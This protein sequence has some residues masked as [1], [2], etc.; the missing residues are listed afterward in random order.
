MGHTFRTEFG[1]I[2]RPSITKSELSVTLIDQP[3]T[4]FYHEHAKDDILFIDATGSMVRQ[5][6]NFKKIL[7]YA[8]II[9]HP[10]DCGPPMPVAEY[11]T[12]NQDPFSIR[13]FLNMIQE[14]ECHKYGTRGK[15]NPK[16][17]LLDFSMALIQACLDEFCAEEFNEYLDRTHCIVTGCASNHALAKSILHICAFHVMKMCRRN[18]K[19]L[20][21]K[22]QDEKSQ[23]HFAS[24]LMGRLINCKSLDEAGRI[25]DKAFVVLRTKKAT[26]DMQD[27]LHWLEESINTFSDIVDDPA[28]LVEGTDDSMNSTLS[29]DHE[30]AEVEDYENYSESIGGARSQMHAFWNSRIGRIDIVCSQSESK[31]L[32]LNRYF[33]PDFCSW[34]EDKLPYITLW[35]NLCIGDLKRHN[36][37]YDYVLPILNK[38]TIANNNTTNAVAENF[39]S[40]KKRNKS[41]LKLSLADFIRKCWKDNRSLGRQFV[42]GLK[43]GMNEKEQRQKQKK[44]LQISTKAGK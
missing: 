42:L 40:L 25:V 1:F 19:R 5:L 34:L 12:S 11:I 30:R 38:N 28:V 10:F 3:M 9:R 14:K 7:Y 36:E 29:S 22:E 32:E 33:M 2:Q 16:L 6:K 18:A 15:T 20:C 26:Q 35:S 23:V 8:A 37:E 17:I 21:N 43:E 27:A 41:N 31:E 39:F 13:R 4:M 44:I 24:R